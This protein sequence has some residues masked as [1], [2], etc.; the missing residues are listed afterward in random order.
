MNIGYARVSTL[1]QKLDL[2]TQALRKTGCKKIFRDNVFSASRELIL[3][4]VDF[5]IEQGAHSRTTEVWLAPSVPR[6]S[7][8]RDELRFGFASPD[9]SAKSG[10]R[11]S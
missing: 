4:A 3:R 6:W 1:D 11:I 8:C 5:R 9:T 10:T 7:R 2:Q